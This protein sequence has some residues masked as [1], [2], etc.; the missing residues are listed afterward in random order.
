MTGY[1]GIA[2]G[3]YSIESVDP[4]TPGAM[5]CGECGRAWLDDITPAGRCPWEE[6]H[7]EEPEEFEP[8]GLDP[9]LSGLLDWHEVQWFRGELFIVHK[10]CG[11]QVAA[12]DP[13]DSL[14]VLVTMAVRHSERC[15][16]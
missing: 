3:A 1:G 12:I 4:A 2:T 6:D 16:R 5:V 13:D 7:E 15:T 14:A 10:P 11:Q 9:D 8:T